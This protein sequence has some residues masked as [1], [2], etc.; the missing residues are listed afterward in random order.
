MGGMPM[1]VF[2]RGAG[3]ELADSTEA[4]GHGSD[5]MGRAA[6]SAARRLEALRGPSSPPGPVS[7]SN[8]ATRLR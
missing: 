2:S 6:L 1:M 4:Q 3:S 7:S 5:E 8:S